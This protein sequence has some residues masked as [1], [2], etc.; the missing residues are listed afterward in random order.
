MTKAL[1]T[2]IFA[3]LMVFALA[4]TVGFEPIVAAKYIIAAGSA[5]EEDSDSKPTLRK[6]LS[7]NS[8]TDLC[9]QQGLGH[10]RL[11]SRI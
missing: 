9:V 2:L 11:G 7:T 3:D 6:E 5:P 10:Y 1:K 4:M 8:L